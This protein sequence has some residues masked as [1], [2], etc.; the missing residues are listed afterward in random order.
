[1]SE[2]LLTSPLCVSDR[3][4][5]DHLASLLHD[6]TCEVDAIEF[7]AEDGVLVLPFRRQFYEGAER[8]IQILDDRTIVEKAWMRS[9]VTLHNVQ[10]W[11]KHDDA[12]I[13]DFSF[14]DWSYARGLLSI[15][16]AQSLTINVNVSGVNAVMEDLGFNGYARIERLSSGSEASSSQVFTAPASENAA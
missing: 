11:E 2:T 12:D 6:E 5:L 9:R 15:Y 16:F 10:G 4:G 7:R 8:V 13:G 14:T 3:V 1:M